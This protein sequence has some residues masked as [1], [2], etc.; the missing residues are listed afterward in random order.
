MRARAAAATLVMLSLSACDSGVGP[1]APAPRPATP[2]PPAP[3]ASASSLPLN[4]APRLELRV[5]PTPIDGKAPL[6]VSV[7][8]CRSTDP[9]RDPLTYVFEYQGE[10]KRFASHCSESHVYRVPASSQAVFCVSDGRPR[11]L[12]CRTFQVRVD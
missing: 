7:N 4:Q 3:T 5:T 11:H 2:S 8:L 10:G 6:S 12:V 9:E 1:A